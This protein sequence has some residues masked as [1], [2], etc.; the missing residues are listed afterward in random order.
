MQEVGAKGPDHE[1]PLAREPEQSRPHLLPMWL[2]NQILII[3]Q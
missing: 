3:R 2:L 1:S